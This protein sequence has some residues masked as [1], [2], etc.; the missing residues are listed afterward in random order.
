MMRVEGQMRPDLPRR[1][2]GK[3]MLKLYYANETY[4]T[5]IIRD[6]A[7]LRGAGLTHREVNERLDL[8]KRS[9]QIWNGERGRFI[10]EKLDLD[11]KVGI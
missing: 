3:T 1:R 11:A 6:I 9:V 4:A 8:P 7:S 5:Q 2:K 10:R